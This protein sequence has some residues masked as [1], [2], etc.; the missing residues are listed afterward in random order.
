MICPEALLGT[1]MGLVEA[2]SAVKAGTLVSFLLRALHTLTIR[3]V[4]VNEV[5]RIA[6]L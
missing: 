3:P 5:T 1:E 4:G 6:L 2:H